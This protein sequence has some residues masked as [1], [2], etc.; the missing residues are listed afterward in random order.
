[1]DVGW[2]WIC[3]IEFWL[4]LTFVLFLSLVLLLELVDWMKIVNPVWFFHRTHPALSLCGL[5]LMPNISHRLTG[6]L[7]MKHNFS[8]PGMATRCM[9]LTSWNRI[10]SEI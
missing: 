1:M 5:N 7:N 6:T 2:G 10:A 8:H 3:R 9:F 4:Y